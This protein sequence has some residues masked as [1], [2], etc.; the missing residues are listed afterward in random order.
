VPAATPVTTPVAEP[1]TATAVFP[2]LHVPPPVVL[3]NVLAAPAHI[4][5]VPVI[6]DGGSATVITSVPWQLPPRLYVIEEVPAVIPITIP[7]ERPTVATDVSL[8]AHVPPLNVLLNVV[9]APMHTEERP[10]TDGIA[11]IVCTRVVKQPVLDIAYV[12]VTVPP[13]TPVTIP[14]EELMVATPVLL[15]LHTPPPVALLNVM[16]APGHT[17]DVPVMAAGAAFTITDIVL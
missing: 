16:L 14:E 17:A 10:V 1:T 12:I 11:F 7:E 4:V 8:L 3:F 6:A 9:V 15:L 13:L 5:I 2:L